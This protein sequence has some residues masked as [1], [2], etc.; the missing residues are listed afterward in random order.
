[1]RRLLAFAAITEALT[2]AG[3]LA[4]PALV[5]KLLL[6]AETTGPGTVAA[7]VAG[8]ALLGLGVACWP[9]RD[10]RSAFA[11]ML[12]YNLLVAVYLGAV[13]LQGGTVGPL[14]WPVVVYHAAMVVPMVIALRRSLRTAA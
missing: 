9:G 3:L 12:V 8:I 11:A 13:A 14:L 10:T 7:R 6:G 2:G 1:M 4:A 5:C